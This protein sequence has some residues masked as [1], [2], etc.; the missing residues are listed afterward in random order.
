MLWNLIIKVHINTLS[1][2]SVIYRTVLRFFPIRS[3]LTQVPGFDHRRGS[4]TS[5]TWDRS[6]RSRMLYQN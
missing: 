4:V 6:R 2:V 1:E 5:R 3:Q